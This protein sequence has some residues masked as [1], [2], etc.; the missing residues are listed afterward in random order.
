MMIIE[1]C[2]VCGAD[3]I[4][5]VL[6]TYPP[7]HGKRCTK[8]DWLWLEEN[9]DDDVIRVPFKPSWPHENDG[10]PECCRNCSNH[11]SNGGSGI[12]C[13]M[14]PY[15]TW[16]GPKNQRGRTFVWTNA[17]HDNGTYTVSDHTEYIFGSGDT[18]GKA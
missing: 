13:C 16:T 14:L 6:T 1:T 5:Y 18:D 10:T 4:D 17:T 3:I 12:C 7:K 9:R 11:P 2:P 15:M 8:C